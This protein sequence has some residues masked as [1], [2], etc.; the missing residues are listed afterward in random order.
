MKNS[1]FVEFIKKENLTQVNTHDYSE[2]V[3]LNNGLE[4]RNVT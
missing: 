4:K 3:Q 2:Q 1:K